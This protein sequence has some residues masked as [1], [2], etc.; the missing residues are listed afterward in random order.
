ML[1]VQF[2]CCLGM[3]PGF[4]V[5]S[6][7]EHSGTEPVTVLSAEMSIPSDHELYRIHGAFYFITNRELRVKILVSIFQ[8]KESVTSFSVNGQQ[9]STAMCSQPPLFRKTVLQ[10]MHATAGPPRTYVRLQELDQRIRL[11]ARER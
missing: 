6:F 11:A 5:F 7:W 2:S 1:T 8:E 9:Y 10:P 4:P 3:A